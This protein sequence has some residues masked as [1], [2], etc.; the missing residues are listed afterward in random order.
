MVT[1]TSVGAGALDVTAPL[2]LYTKV[3]FTKIVGTDVAHAVRPNP[4]AGFGS[5]H[6]WK[7]RLSTARH[8][9]HWLDSKHLD[10]QSFKLKSGGT[11]GTYGAGTYFGIY[12]SKIALP[13]FNQL[14][15]MCILLFI[16]MLKQLGFK[17][18]SSKVQ[19]KV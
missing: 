11:L 18:P 17:K 12:R 15:G 13:G 16:I 4:V 2:I 14:I 1:L 9:A 3:N 7:C 6:A 5:C 10:W 8:T 19:E